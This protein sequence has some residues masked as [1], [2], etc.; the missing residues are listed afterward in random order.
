MA[1]VI[2]FWKYAANA[3]RPRSGIFDTSMLVET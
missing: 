2:A 3:V 1:R